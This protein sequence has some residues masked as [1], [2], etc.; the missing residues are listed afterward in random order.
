MQ[1]QIHYQG[2]DHTPWMDQFISQRVSKLNRYLNSAAKIHVHLKIENRK[3]ITTLSIHNMNH[4]YAFTSPGENL[5]ESFQVATDK[6]ARTL[7][8]YKRKIK[9]KIHRKFDVNQAVA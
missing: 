5:Y 7:G 1:I 3:Y 2:L 6:A 9:D 4:D 8:E